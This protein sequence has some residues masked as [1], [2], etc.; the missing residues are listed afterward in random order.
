MNHLACLGPLYFLW[1][2]FFWPLPFCDSLTV[3]KWNQICISALHFEGLEKVSGENKKKKQRNV[4]WH[5]PLMDIWNP[6]L[7][8]WGELNT[9]PKS[10]FE[11]WIEP[12]D[13]NGLINLKN[14]SFNGWKFKLLRTTVIVS[15]FNNP[16][17]FHHLF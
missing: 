8:K 6:S 17:F 13:L 15:K 4:D 11:V 9:T 7:P 10:K 3:P 14:S 12:H 1:V 5:S 16:K 2:F